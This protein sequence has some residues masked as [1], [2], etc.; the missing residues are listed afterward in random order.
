MVDDISVTP[1]TDWIGADK[2]VIAMQKHANFSEGVLIAYRVVPQYTDQNKVLVYECIFRDK[3]RRKNPFHLGNI[4]HTLGGGVYDAIERE[5]QLSNP[6]WWMINEPPKEK[7]VHLQWRPWIW[8]NDEVKGQFLEW[9]DL[10]FFGWTKEKWKA[11]KYI[12]KRQEQLNAPTLATIIETEQLEQ[13]TL[14]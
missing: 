6:G 3:G 14:F 8:K 11:N 7:M 13:M 4:H 1:C 12:W 5:Y 9:H 10:H 2:Q